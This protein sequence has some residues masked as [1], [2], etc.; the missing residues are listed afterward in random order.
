MKKLLG[1]I[2]ALFMAVGLVAANVGTTSV[3]ATAATEYTYDVQINGK[4]G[5]DALVTDVKI[6]LGEDQSITDKTGVILKAINLTKLS[7]KVS[8]SK[9]TT[10]ADEN[11]TG[12]ITLV[13]DAEVVQVTLHG[14]DEDGNE[15]ATKQVA[16]V[17]E[18]TL[19]GVLPADGAELTDGVLVK[20]GWFDDSTLKKETDASASITDT[21]DLDKYAS[22]DYKEYKVTFNFN[23]GS[24]S[25]KRTSLTTTAKNQTLKE[26]VENNKVYNDTEGSNVDLVQDVLATIVYEG[27][28]P[29]SIGSTEVGW[30]LDAACTKK[31]S[32]TNK[33][34]TEDLV[35]YAKFETKTMSVDIIDGVDNPD[36][37]LSKGVTYVDST[38]ANIRTELEQSGI[39]VGETV[40]A[41]VQLFNRKDYGFAGWHVYID[42]YDEND[43]KVDSVHVS[44][45]VDAGADVTDAVNKAA[46]SQFAKGYDVTIVFEA[47]WSSAAVEVRYYGQN[48]QLVAK[49]TAYVDVS[50]SVSDEINKVGLLPVYTCSADGKTYTPYDS[51]DASVITTALID[52]G[53]ELHLSDFQDMP[54]VTLNF[55]YGLGDNASSKLN[56]TRQYNTKINGPDEEASKEDLEFVGWSKVSGFVTSNT[57]TFKGKYSSVVANSADELALYDVKTSDDLADVD[58]ISYN[59]GTSYSAYYV[60]VYKNFKETKKDD[61]DTTVAVY[62]LYN[63]NTGE[64]LFTVDANEVKVLTGLGW[65]DEGIAWYAPEEG[66][67]VY[68]LYNPNVEGGEHHYTTNEA[69][70]AA[71]VAL[72][73]VK[74]DVSFMSATQADGVAIYRLYNSNAYS[75][76]HHFTTDK[77]E[78]DTLIGLGW[79]GEEI[80]FYAAKAAE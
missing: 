69:E 77:N 63:G 38:S 41:P 74:D 15:I 37:G 68:R 72:G 34:I 59:G 76:N 54:Q 62:R 66:T 44:T 23:G 57:D 32:K 80:G 17:K 55:Y 78:N 46:K 43:N 4:D 65:T 3:N 5:T 12:L 28:K 13:V 50:Y 2:L 67:P 52:D 14:L 16:I 47:L 11:T 51:I 9:V 21:T 39:D 8:D 27:D 18:D 20:E 73:W 45:K 58:E 61:V 33:K 56:V 71:L 22:V 64:H 35:L 70:V 24:A 29:Y 40:T 26:V 1:V 48:N 36:K 79:T 42:V 31:Y 7:T 53:I 30:Y 75:N 6:T 19:A 49:D 25:D 60:A 10:K